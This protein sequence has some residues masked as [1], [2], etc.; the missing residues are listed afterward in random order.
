MEAK[1]PSHN[2]GLDLSGVGLQ[3]CGS[4]F[5]LPREKTKRSRPSLDFLKRNSTR[6]QKLET[7]LQ[8]DKDR[9]GL[10]KRHVQGVRFLFV[11]MTMS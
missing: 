2:A 1:E 11:G 10:E 8:R 7:W 6:P 3:R 9:Q 5:F 4:S